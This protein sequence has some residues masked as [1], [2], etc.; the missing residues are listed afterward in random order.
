MQNAECRMQNAECPDSVLVTARGHAKIPVL[1]LAARGGFEDTDAQLRLRDYDSPEEAHGAPPD[2]RSDTYSVGAILYEML[3][4]R[5]PMHRGAAAPSAS[6]RHVQ[7]ELDQVALKAVSP[8][9]D[10]RYQSVAALAGEL[11]RVGTLLDAR[12]IADDADDRHTN[13]PSGRGITLLVVVVIVL[14]VVIVWW[15]TRS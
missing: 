1:E 8:N 2:E 12:G 14:G 10:S 3:T 6:N 11:R 7:P 13:S 5:R 9:P 15:L 4:T